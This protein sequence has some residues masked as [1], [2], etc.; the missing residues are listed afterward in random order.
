[1]LADDDVAFTASAL[2]LLT[3]WCIWSDSAETASADPKVR[4]AN[5]S[6]LP[7]DFRQAAIFLDHSSAVLPSL[8]LNLRARVRIATKF[9]DGDAV[10]F[11]F[12]LLS[13]ARFRQLPFEFSG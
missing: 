4:A 6:N 12:Q 2:Q 13:E 5:L 3:N 1:M 10:P 7:I 11:P 9:P 8:Q